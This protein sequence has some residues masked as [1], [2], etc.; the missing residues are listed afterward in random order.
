M[1]R[2]AQRPQASSGASERV[3]RAWARHPLVA[4]ARHR[5]RLTFYVGFHSM[6]K[7]GVPLSIA[8]AGG[9]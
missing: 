3:A 6:L 9:S 8:F 2:T 4:M 1:V 5:K 7:A